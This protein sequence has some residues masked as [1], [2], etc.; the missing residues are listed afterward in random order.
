VRRRKMTDLDLQYADGRLLVKDVSGSC[1]CILCA[2]RVNVS[3]LNLTANV[4]AKKLAAR[5]KALPKT[6]PVEAAAPLAAQ[7]KPEQTAAPLATQKSPELT[8]VDTTRLSHFL[9][10]FVR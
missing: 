7:K 3:L 6:G 4:A 9:R 5:M 2:P 8:A 1:L 10:P